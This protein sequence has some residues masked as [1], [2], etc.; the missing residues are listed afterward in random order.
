MFNVE[1]IRVE[2]SKEYNIVIKKKKVK[3]KK[4]RTSF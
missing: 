1:C 2:V 3:N 4:C